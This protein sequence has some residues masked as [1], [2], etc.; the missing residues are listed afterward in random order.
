MNTNTYLNIVFAG[1]SE[2][3]LPSLNALLASRHKIAAVYTVPDRPAGRGQKNTASFVKMR[4]LQNNL[5]IYQPTTLRDSKEQEILKNLS[6]DIMIDVAYGL[7]LPKEILMT[8]KFGCINI[9]PSLLPRW[10]GAA[11]I[12][13]T[14]LAGDSETGVTVMQID[15]GL[16]TGDVLRQAKIT[17]N[18][19]ET[20]EFLHNK[21]AVIGAELLLQTLDDL[22]LGKTQPTK[23]DGALACYANKITKEE[24]LIN[25]TLSAKEIDRMVRAFNPWP[26]AF[27]TLSG[28]I[29]RI[30]QT[31]AL[32]YTDD[33]EQS[34]LIGNH[35]TILEVSKD[36]IDVV[37][38]KGLL[39]LLKLQLPGRKVLSV[40]EILNS[41]ANLFAKGVC[42]NG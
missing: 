3:A 6:A 2:F 23:Q 24:G 10:R 28:E 25:W 7:L 38:G 37:T 30:W 20:S 32:E 16:D 12:Q 29:V 19:S 14:I 33:D 27:T 4:A 39:R 34:K 31:K 40:K 9:H 36:G 11:P 18:G 13:R 35:G 8:F 42:F 15:E 5:P 17:L 22:L 26:V 41:R 1:T 21:L